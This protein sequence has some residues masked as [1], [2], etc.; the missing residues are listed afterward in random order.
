[1][2]GKNTTSSEYGRWLDDIGL[3]GPIQNNMDYDE[4]PGFVNSNVFGRFSLDDLDF[5]DDLTKGRIDFDDEY[6]LK[7]LSSGSI[8]FS[9]SSIAKVE[10]RDSYPKRDSSGGYYHPPHGSAKTAERRVPSYADTPKKTHESITRQMPTVGRTIQERVFEGLE[11]VAGDLSSNSKFLESAKSFMDKAPTKWKLFEE[12]RRSSAIDRKQSVRNHQVSPESVTVT[13]TQAALAREAA[14]AVKPRKAGQ[15]GKSAGTGRNTGIGRRVSPIAVILI[16]L[17]IVRLVAFLFQASTHHINITH[18]EPDPKPGGT[19]L[20]GGGDDDKKDEMPE[21]IADEFSELF[22]DIELWRLDNPYIPWMGLS[23]EGTE[24]LLKDAGW[25][26]AEIT[27]NDEITGVEAELV[28]EHSEAYIH[29]DSESIGATFYWN[30]PEYSDGQAEDE[31][32][33]AWGNLFPED[34]GIYPGMQLSE[35][36]ITDEMLQAIRDCGEKN[37]YGVTEESSLSVNGLFIA[38]FDSENDWSL[39][40]NGDDTYIQLHTDSEGKYLARVYISGETNTW[41]D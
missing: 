24:M 34:S 40:I 30:T 32:Q 26:N 11:E 4:I 29:V 13:E 7:S 12:Q 19:I 5:G 33:A 6:L 20:I 9:E 2:S 37:N 17:L 31:I 14:P 16:M 21:E 27:E 36:R 25:A 35:L 39:Y 15:S 38:L 22:N 23:A 41:F 10:T 8:V 3:S 18:T 28:Q 1:M